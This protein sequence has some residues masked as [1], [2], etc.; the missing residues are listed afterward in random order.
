VN[1]GQVTFVIPE[2][3]RWLPSGCTDFPISPCSG[4]FGRNSNRN[5]LMKLQGFPPFASATVRKNGKSCQTFTKAGRQS[6]SRDASRLLKINGGQ[7]VWRGSRRA[8]ARQRPG[9]LRNEMAILGV[10]GENEGSD[11]SLP[12]YLN[13]N[14][15]RHLT[16]GSDSHQRSKRKS[17]CFR[18]FPIRIAAHPHFTPPRPETE[19]CL[20]NETIRQPGLRLGSRGW[21]TEVLFPSEHA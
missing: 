5:T 6:V 11:G 20:P 15:S 13:S 19:L 18:H 14:R 8:E 3:E 1:H 17:G 7:R 4:P 9:L 2:R 12:Y 16:G 10:E 21:M